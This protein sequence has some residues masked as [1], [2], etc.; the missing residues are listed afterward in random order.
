MA[1]GLKNSC[2]Y[3]FYVVADR[4]A[5]TTGST[6]TLAQWGEKFGLT[7]STGIELTGEVVGQVGSQNVLYDPPSRLPPQI[8]KAWR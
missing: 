5:Q 4:I 1:E 3:F 6:D 8:W 2:N 7:S